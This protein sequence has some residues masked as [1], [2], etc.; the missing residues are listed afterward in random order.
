MEGLEL[1]SDFWR[2]K[3]VFL[4]GHTGFKGAWLSLWLSDSGAEVSGYSLDVPTTPSFFEIARVAGRIHDVRGDI[5]NAT[6]TRAAIQAAAPDVVI[7]MA[8]QSLVRQSYVSPVATYATNVMG[9]VHLLEAVREVSSV[10]AV[11][12]VTSDKCY[13]NR[14]WSR[15]YKESDPMGGR[16]PYSSSKGCQEIVT[17]AL[18]ASFFGSPNGGAAVATARAG[19][20]IGG[21]DWAA[22]RLVPDAM[23][24]FA[25]GKALEI[26][27]PGAIRPWQHVLEP[28]SGYLLLA[29]RLYTDGARW[30][31]GWN[32]GPLDEDARSVE[33]VVENVARRWGNGARWIA[34]HGTHPHEAGL[35][36]LDCTKARTELGWSP[37][38]RL[39]RALDAVVDWY[40]AYLREADM[41]S[42]SLQQIEDYTR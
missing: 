42:F 13:E 18:R 8:A 28:L 26:R 12:V 15:G 20:V 6:E 30:A 29:E 14:E 1:N 31:E 39:G 38:W 24:A 27:N 2:G 9:T 23:R 11:V 36:K 35:L 21:G 7:H 17:S 22:D 3:K 40:R 33:F 25:Q 16:D 19:N 41:Q 34:P 5:R 37:K 32:F 10:R 4:T